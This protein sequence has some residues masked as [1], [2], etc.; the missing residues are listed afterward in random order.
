MICFPHAKINLGL[1]VLNK[2]PD[3]FHNIATLFYPIP[4]HD[5]LEIV[6]A[7]STAL[8]LSGLAVE[9]APEDNLCMKAYRLLER[10]GNMKCALL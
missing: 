6:P 9:G 3:G 7:A 4:F 1:H 5:V 2:R 10:Q 8:H